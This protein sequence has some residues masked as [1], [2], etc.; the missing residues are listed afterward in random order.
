LEVSARLKRALDALDL[1]G[2]DPVWGR[3]QRLCINQE[4]S[5]IREVIEAWKESKKEEDKK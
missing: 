3:L 2:W 1:K 4:A 5:L